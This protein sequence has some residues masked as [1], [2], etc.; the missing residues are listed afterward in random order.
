MYISKIRVKNYK[1][2]RDSKDIEFKKGINIII[3]QNNA[4]KTALLEVVEL[5]FG[6]NP[7]KSEKSI[8]ERDQTLAERFSTASASL[9]LETD[10]LKYIRE[11][12]KFS[13]VYFLEPEEDK[14]SVFDHLIKEFNNSFDTGL[15]I[16][17]DT[18]VD[19]FFETRKAEF[20]AS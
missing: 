12:D 19:L 18:E 10:D 15:I 20:S 17:F 13:T 3:G 16:S 1:S 2:F 14:S 6:N 5:N 9:T 8:S 11:N 7:H 4:G